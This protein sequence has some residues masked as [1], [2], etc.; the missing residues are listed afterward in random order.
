[1]RWVS[2]GLLTPMIPDCSVLRTP[3]IFKTFVIRSFFFEKWLLTH[4]LACPK[5]K[6]PPASFACVGF[7]P[8]DN[9]IILF[10]YIKIQKVFTFSPSGVY[11]R[12][13]PFMVY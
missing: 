3:A 2:K 8:F 7:R 9:G 10:F 13:R 1:M 6:N 11:R 5:F 4:V 12:F